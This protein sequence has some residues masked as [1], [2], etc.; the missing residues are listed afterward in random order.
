MIKKDK[1]PVSS[2]LFGVGVIQAVVGFLG[3]SVHGPKF[4]PI[5]WVI[6]FSFLIFIVLAIA[7][8]WARVPAAVIAAAIY[9]AFL[10]LQASIS[11]QLLMAGM[12]FKIPNVILLL[13]A[14]VLAF[15]SRKKTEEAKGFCEP[16]DAGDA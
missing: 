11:I 10:L 15:K 13:V 3:W 6:T 12:I 7:A 9:G 14:L 1:H 16:A 4:A 5:D 2:A 8:R